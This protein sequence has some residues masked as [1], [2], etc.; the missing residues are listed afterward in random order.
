VGLCVTR[1][2]DSAMVTRFM[3][4]L[5][6]GVALAGCIDSNLIDCGDRACPGGS[7]CVPTGCAAPDQVTAC[8]GLPDGTE[9]DTKEFTGGACLTGVC[10][11]II[12]GDGIVVP[13]EV[14]D[15][16]NQLSGDGCSSDCRSTETC[17]NGVVDGAS[18]EQCDNLPAGLSH[19]GCSST[20]GA[21][22]EVWIDVSPNAPPADSAAAMGYDAKRGRTVMFTS[23]GETWEWDGIVWRHFQPT[24]APTPRQNA[25]FAYDPVHDQLLLVGG[26]LAQVTTRA[27]T[28]QWDGMS[29]TQI[30]VSAP[31]ASD[32]PAL[33]FD[34]AHQALVLL[35]GGTTWGWDGT[36]WHMVGLASPSTGRAMAFD[37]S[38]NTLIAFD[39]DG[40][41]WTFDG[42]TWTALSTLTHP[43]GRVGMAMTNDSQGI[44]LY[45]G[46]PGGSETWRWKNGMWTELS[47]PKNPGLLSGAAVAF[48]SVRDRIVLYGG[49]PTSNT[50]EWDGTNWQTIMY[51][52][53]PSRRHDA[54]SIYQSA[55]GQILLFGGVD[56]DP[57]SPDGDTW[58]WDG[59]AWI[60]DSYSGSDQIPPARR[61]FGIVA[62]PTG[63][64]MFGGSGK[65]ALML[66]DTWQWDGQH[67]LV[68]NPTH[69]PA[70]RTELALSYDSARGVTVMFGGQGAAGPL[71]DTWE[72]DGSDWTQR[73]PAH[74]PPA[75]AG[76]V[77][78]YDPA[79]GKTTLFGGLDV[80]GKSLDDTWE[81][82]GTDWTE[83]M[84]IVSPPP[85]L[86][87][88]AA[89]DPSR[90]TIAVFGGLANTR[91]GT[92]LSD[93]WEWDG[94]SWR[95]S[96]VVQGPP[97]QSGITLA[98]DPIAGQLV[99]FDANGLTRAHRW[100]SPIDPAD[101][102]LGPDSDGDGLAGCADPDCWARCTPLCPPHATC[103]PTSPHCGDGVCSAVENHDI[104][105]TD[106]AP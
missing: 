66:A 25:G 61:A 85:R 106:C 80:S 67:W 40:V 30:A 55:T 70:V 22:F 81:W 60:P 82:D 21:E 12:C 98:Y 17:G 89:Y 38:G 44:L 18:G 24:V 14:C 32:S 15:D 97:A 19:D 45:G 33:A 74:Q 73:L 5:I 29:W 94:T 92:L 104:C 47:P 8:T 69:V 96:A 37:P 39:P 51:L 78:S 6:V 27:E 100:T 105:P 75:R 28:W 87:A 36:T 101:Q 90:G 71:A 2:Y 76:A 59:V 64:V 84:P 68:Q 43:A 56:T 50:Y 83:P 54:G 58:Q 20:C 23:S 49:G 31:V 3:L 16:G 88:S 42:T 65:G 34:S 46:T 26:Q 102:C 13:P 99:L 4:G 86:E 93:L 103:A 91:L 52:L 9:C 72:Y 95:L 10:L 1:P 62:T 77:M 35:A 57:M 48:D 79:R 11:Q 53:A 63:A 41:T 7:V